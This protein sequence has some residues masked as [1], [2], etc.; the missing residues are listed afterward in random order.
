MQ[1]VNDYKYELSG[2]N[3]IDKHNFELKIEIFSLCFENK[4]TL[5]CKYLI[6]S[7][8]GCMPSVVNFISTQ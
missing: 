4:Y 6:L 3:K 8:D 5:F 2:K 1:I 7:P